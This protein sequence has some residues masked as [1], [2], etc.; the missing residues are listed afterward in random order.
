MKPTRADGPAVLA[1]AARPT[2]VAGSLVVNSKAARAIALDKATPR[3]PLPG[4]PQGFEMQRSR[5]QAGSALEGTLPLLL[6]DGPSGG[7]FIVA[8]LGGNA[9]PFMLHLYA[10]WAEKERRLNPSERKCAAGQRKRAGARPRQTRHNLCHGRAHRTH[11]HSASLPMSSPQIWCRNPGD[12]QHG[13][14]YPERDCTTHSTAA[15]SEP[16]LRGSN[17]HRSFR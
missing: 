4:H 14:A 1:A 8:E 2:I 6:A 5:R 13:G 15:A 16:P 9:D 17:W 12:P 10:A 7:R 3:W 11:L